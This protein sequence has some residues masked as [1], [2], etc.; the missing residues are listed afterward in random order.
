MS[1]GDA[2]HLSSLV[3][4]RPRRLDLLSRYAVDEHPDHVVFHLRMAI[5]AD[6]GGDNHVS[7]LGVIEDFI[8]GEDSAV[9]E[10]WGISILAL[11]AWFQWVR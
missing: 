4:Q 10:I 1:K 8:E 5:D 11:R 6:E 3:A 2:Q 7:G 9:E